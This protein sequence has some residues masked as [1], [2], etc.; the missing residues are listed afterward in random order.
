M[1]NLLNQG[2]FPVSFTIVSDCNNTTEPRTYKNYPTF[3]ISRIA[4]NRLIIDV[5]I[6]ANCCSNFLGEAEIIGKDTLNLLYT[7]YGA[8]CAC[9]CRYS[10]RYIFNDFSK[11]HGFALKYIT[12]NGSIK[13]GLISDKK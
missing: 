10:L 1:I 2:L 11:D 13:Y 6:I 5:D 9:S 12:V 4:P 3:K 8:Y 7:H